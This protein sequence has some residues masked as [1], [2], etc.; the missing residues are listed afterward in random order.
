M[1]PYPH[2]DVVDEVEVRLAVK[3]PDVDELVCVGL[4]LR[5]ELIDEYILLITE[6]QLRAIVAEMER[7]LAEPPPENLFER[8]AKEAEQR[9]PDEQEQ[10]GPT[11]IDT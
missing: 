11:S 10:E 5:T 1:P 3:C 6:K 4:C 9:G 7:L 8:L 2:L